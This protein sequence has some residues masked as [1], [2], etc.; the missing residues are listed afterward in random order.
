M[1]GKVVMLGYMNVKMGIEKVEGVVGVWKVPGANPN[2]EFLIDFCVEGGV[3]IKIPTSNIS[4]L[5]HI[6][7]E[8][9]GKGC[10]K[11]H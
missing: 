7:G 10:S 6:C 4:L 1:E 11:K 2:S 9:I 3:F 5:I 8:E